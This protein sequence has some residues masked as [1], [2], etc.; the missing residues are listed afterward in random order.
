MID[1][2][3]ARRVLIFVAL[4]GLASGTAAVVLGRQDAA[5]LIWTAATVPVVIAL[6]VSVVRDLAA[7]RLG[8]D[9]IALLAMSGALVLGQP[10][11][12]IVVA[13]MYT[14]GTVLRQHRPAGL[15]A[16]CR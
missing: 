6:A 12:G 2:R 16:S 4:L 14:G 3:L 7:R 9:A 15:P 5:D 1:E 10:L 8:V 11:A 13:I